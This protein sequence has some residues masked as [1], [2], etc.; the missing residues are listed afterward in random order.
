MLQ[1]GHRKNSFGLHA[2][3]LVIPLTHLAPENCQ[4]PEKTQ[5]PLLQVFLEA[6]RCQ[7]IDRIKACQEK[8]DDSSCADH[9]L[10]MRGFVIIRTRPP[11]QPR[12]IKI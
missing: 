7:A 4:P 5:L 8:L 9:A 1:P 12:V 2:F 6:P 3:D 11:A 10:V